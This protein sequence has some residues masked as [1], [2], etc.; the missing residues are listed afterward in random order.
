MI[1]V[2]IADPDATARKALARLLEHRL[3]L[4]C[5]AEAGEIE[6]LIKSLADFPPDVLFLDW[7]LHGL[8]APEFSRL[9]HKAYADLRVVLLSL[10]EKDEELAEAAGATF[11]HKGACLD[12]L[13]KTLR[14]LLTEEVP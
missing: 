3:G 9:I 1:R 5:I 14:P 2:L 8:P 12:E 11:V 6:T 4:T 7:G 10:D 13:I